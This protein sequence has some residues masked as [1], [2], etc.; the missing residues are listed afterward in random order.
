MPDYRHSH[1]PCNIDHISKEQGH[2]DN[3]PFYSCGHNTLA[4]KWKWGWDGPYLNTKPPLFSYRNSAWKILV[5]IRTTWFS[6]E[7]RES[8]IKTRSTPALF[9]SILNW[10]TTSGSNKYRN[11]AAKSKTV[12]CTSANS[13]TQWREYRQNTVLSFYLT[14]LSFHY[15]KSS[16]FC[17]NFLLFGSP[18]LCICLKSPVFMC[19]SVNIL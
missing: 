5:S 10:E 1:H 6:Q 19:L 17:I 11:V 12:T 8:C 7:S 13:L 18:S 16:S 9:P 15:R 2:W 4:F 14:I 3:K